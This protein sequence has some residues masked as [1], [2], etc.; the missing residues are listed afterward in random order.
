MSK[1]LYVTRP[2]L[3][4]LK[5][6][7]V[8]LSE[9]WRTQ[10]VTNGGP[11]HEKLETALTGT[12]GVPN[13]QLFNNGTIAL[14]VALK[15]FNLP[16]GSEVITTPLT[17]A[18]TAHSIH[19]NGLRPVFADVSP[20]TLTIDPASVEKAIT[21]LTS[22]ILGVHVYGT[23]CD[24]EALQQ[25]ADQYGLRLIYDAAHAFGTTI[26]GR[27][28]ASFGDASIFSFH[29]TKLFTTLEGGAIATPH[30]DNHEMIYFLRN[31]GIKS[32]EDVVSIGINGKMNE[33]Q[34]A[35]GLLNLPKVPAEREARA[36]L[37]EKLDKALSGLHG[38]RL[39]PVQPGVGQSEQ[40]YPVVINAELFGRKRDAIY[41]SLKDIGILSRKYFHPIC[42]DFAPYRGFPIISARNTPYVSEVKSQVLCLPFFSGVSDEDVE[43]IRTVFH[44][45]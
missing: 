43:A 31:F 39:Q 1:P 13:V 44:A 42:T 20:D 24:V 30:I 18:A 7:E 21:P 33:V 23:V 32:E 37:R 5:D 6:L 12:L 2:L 45:A 34:A 4:D 14:L 9:I 36:R 29:A 27:P 11:F 19:W 10:F 35:I 41:N 40:Y 28:I 16:P 3:P 22:A 17:F 25:I 15:L 8:M 26:N 38:I